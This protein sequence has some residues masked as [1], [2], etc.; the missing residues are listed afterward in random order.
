MFKTAMSTILITSLLLMLLIMSGCG[1]SGG[2]SVGQ[3]TIKVTDY[4]LN[5]YSI[6]NPDEGLIEDG[7]P[8]AIV[9]LQLTAENGGV[10]DLDISFSLNVPGIDKVF[11]LKAYS[12]NDAEIKDTLTEHNLNVEEPQNIT[13]YVYMDKNNNA[14]STLNGLA[15]TAT[16]KL[17]ISIDP[18]KKAG[19]SSESDK[20]T[21]I[22][23][24]Y[25]PDQL[26][27]SDALF[28]FDPDASGYDINFGSD[29][30]H[31][32]NTYTYDKPIKAPAQWL[33]AD[34]VLQTGDI[35]RANPDYPWT[36]SGN[37]HAYRL[38]SKISWPGGEFIPFEIQNNIKLDSHSGSY[39]QYTAASNDKTIYYKFYP[40]NFTGDQ[41]S[42]EF[43]IPSGNIESKTVSRNVFWN[44]NL[45][46]NLIFT[47]SY[48]SI[49]S[50][51][52]GMDPGN[53]KAAN[54]TIDR[55]YNKLV[56]DVQGSMKTDQ[57]LITDDSKIRLID[58]SQSSNYKLNN[59]L[60]NNMPSPKD[61]KV[62]I[63]YDNPSSYLNGDGTMTM[64]RINKEKHPMYPH[65][66]TKQIYNTNT[67]GR[68]YS[69]YYNNESKYW[70][71]IVGPRYVRAN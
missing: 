26:F 22:A 60:V 59:Y 50:S 29:K 6:V 61:A 69:T 16:C 45:T 13:Y 35:A 49:L 18:S 46:F 55:Q 54:F 2:S 38:S 66:T 64:V 15:S 25:I 33:K 70:E 43:P 8:I 68:S 52:M 11:P 37:L 10:D 63:F 14:L 24:E 27:I 36:A 47:G 32:D 57:Y 48:N 42:L 19:I 9:N 28:S 12:S 51:K 31:Y 67:Q 17:I 39:I 41:G 62:E 20:A 5:S 3:P 1:S 30:I 56:V 71:N 21:Y 53:P 44:T 4:Q 7:K 58:W 34:V 23:M 65:S 40:F